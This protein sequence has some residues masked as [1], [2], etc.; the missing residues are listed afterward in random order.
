MLPSEGSVS[1]ESLRLIAKKGIQWIGTDEDIL[2][3]STG[4]RFRDSA[5]NLIE[6]DALYRPYVFENVSIIFR[7]HS[8]SDLI[9]FVYSQWDPKK[10]AED[11]INRLLQAWSAVPKNRPHLLSI[12]LDGENAWEDYKNDGHDFLSYLYEGLSREKRLKTVT[13]SEYLKMHGKGEP[14]KRLHSGS[15]IYANFAVWIGHEEEN[16]A[17][18]YLTATREDLDLYQKMNPAKDL[19]EAWKAIYI[20]EG[21]DW[22]WWYG[23]DHSTDNQKDFDELF[24]T[25]LM[26]VYKEI[27]KDIPGRLF[28]PVPR[29]DRS[30][31]PT[32]TIRGV[33]GQRTDGGVQSYSEGDRGAQGG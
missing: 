19:S 27:G 10:A 28:I 14:L 7:D 2:A 12:I 8:L 13:P 9:G 30:I 24:R 20:A 3:I 15:W 16:R 6:A 23:D 29:E 26:K 25:N 11:L 18:D 22:N 32:V 21:S 1:E 33:I 5:R 31:S 4:K 17:W